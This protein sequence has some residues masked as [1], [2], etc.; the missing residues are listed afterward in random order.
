ME[1]CSHHQEFVSEIK[2]LHL[3]LIDGLARIETKQDSV[4]PMNIVL[5]PGH[6]GSDP[7]AVGPRRNREADVSL[8]VCMLLKQELAAQSHSVILTRDTDRDVAGPGVS[9]SLELQSR[10]DIANRSGADLFLSVHCNAFA[11]P[12]AH[13]TETWYYSAGASLA[14]AVQRRL[15]ALGLMDRGIKQGNLYVLKHTAMPAVLAEIAFISN[16]AEETLLMNEGFLRAVARALAQGITD[17]KMGGDENAISEEM[18]DSF[19]RRSTASS[20]P[21]KESYS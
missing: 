2:H 7:G 3:E 16:P 15:A 21:G 9:A 11:N 18:A 12:A 5:D 17:T 1:Q 4:T 10:C 8:A 6:G 14:A 13:G 20:A 19:R